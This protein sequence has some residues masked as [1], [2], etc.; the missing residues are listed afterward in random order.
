VPEVR[1][2]VPSGRA[3]YGMASFQNKVYIF[4][5]M[6]EYGKYSN[7]L[8]ELDTSTWE[9]RRVE[10]TLGHL[11]SARLGHSFTLAGERI[12]LFG[13][14]EN[15]SDSPKENVP[16]YLS[17]LHVLDVASPSGM[18]WSCPPT[19]GKGPSARESHTAVV[20]QNSRCVTSL[21]IYGGMSGYR[22]GDV[23]LLNLDTNSWFKPTIK[24][25]RAVELLL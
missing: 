20:Y 18:S 13:G 21:V 11:P 9:W 22:L 6:V 5:G 2:E 17:D 25:N 15:A 23:W 12:Y 19:Y 4:G 16:K 24:G 7:D 14:L 1:G 8:Y 3:A 10:V